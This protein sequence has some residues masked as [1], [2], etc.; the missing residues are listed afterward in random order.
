ML[1]GPDDAQSLSAK[2]DLCAG[3]EPSVSWVEVE[4]HPWKL[5]AGG[6]QNEGTLKK[7]AKRLKIWSIF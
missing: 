7:V 6:P 3:R 1:P 4:V 5:T 2:S